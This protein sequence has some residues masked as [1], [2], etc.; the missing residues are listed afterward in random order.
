MLYIFK[1]LRP[2]ERL[3][4]QLPTDLTAKD[5]GPPEAIDYTLNPPREALDLIQEWICVIHVR[6]I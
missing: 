4:A 3:Y 2:K 6:I 1:G 5:V